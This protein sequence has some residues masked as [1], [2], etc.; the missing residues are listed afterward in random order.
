MAARP[1]AMA[2]AG[3]ALPGAR[4]CQEWMGLD[5]RA[6]QGWAELGRVRSR[7]DGSG[8][9]GPG[10]TRPGLAWRQEGPSQAGLWDRVGLSRPGLGLAKGWARLGWARPGPAG[11][12]WRRA[13]PSVAGSGPAG[14]KWVGSGRVGSGRVGSGRV[15]R[16]EGI[17][18]SANRVGLCWAGPGC[19]QAGLGQ[20]GPCGPG[21]RKSQSQIQSQISH[22]S[23]HKSVTNPVTNQSQIQSQISLNVDSR[24]CA[25]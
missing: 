7:R 16:R 13:R 1:M 15:G 22:K 9:A 23:S 12:A 18:D 5:E 8:R 11:S 10:L 25:Y 19:G 6:G 21:V 14:P 17:S 20:A 3:L 24:E 4:P 2:M